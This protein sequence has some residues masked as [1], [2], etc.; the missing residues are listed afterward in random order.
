LGFTDVYDYT[1]GK[2]D[3]LAAGLP[4]EGT[5]TIRVGDLAKKD[6]PTCGLDERLADVVARAKDWGLCVVV[7]PDRIVLGLLRAK[8]L[9]GDPNTRVE[10]AMR[11]GPSTFRPHVAPVEMAAYMVEHDLEKALITTSDGTLVGV[12]LRDDVVHAAHQEHEGGSSE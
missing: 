11:P 1:A 12:A 6:V 8:E 7:S 5:K 9:G 2:L 10:D 4:F 3:W